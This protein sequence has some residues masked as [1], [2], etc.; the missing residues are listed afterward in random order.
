MGLQEKPL[1]LDSV[2]E[3]YDGSR[4]IFDLGKFR[5][6]TQAGERVAFV[7]WPALLL[8]E[9]GPVLVRGIAQGSNNLT[10]SLSKMNAN[11]IS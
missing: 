3:K 9:D 5:A 11:L 10:I 6:F 8:H 4:K 7:V 2:A 1:H